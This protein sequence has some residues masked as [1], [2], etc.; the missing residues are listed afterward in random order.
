MGRKSR[1]KKERGPAAPPEAPAP[2]P[3]EP[4]S[5]D[6]PAWPDP[7]LLALVGAGLLVVVGVL[8]A[9]ELAR[10]PRAILV[11]QR[12]ALALAA[13]ALAAW[14]LR[15]RLSLDSEVGLWL[16]TAGL[17]ILALAA[18]IAPAWFDLPMAGIGERLGPIPIVVGA[19]LAGLGLLAGRGHPL[20]L[21]AGGAGCAVLLAGLLQPHAEVIDLRLA[22]LHHLAPFSGIRSAFV[23]VLLLAAAGG[24]G[25]IA[26]QARWGRP[27][28]VLLV[29][30]LPAWLLYRMTTGEL[31]G[32][33]TALLLTAGATCWMAAL[34][35]LRAAR[36]RAT[37]G[38]T[39]EAAG[40]VLAVG[41]W[42]LLKSYTW[43]W[44]TTDENI[45]FYD[46][47]LWAQGQLPYKDFFFAHPPMHIGV[48]ALAFKIFGFSLPLAKGIPVVA[49]L[50]TGL[51]LWMM[52]RRRVG[53]LPAGL[54][55]VAFLFAH[56][57]LQASTNL[58]GVNLTSFWLVLGLF[59]AT[60]GRSR[61]IA[62]GVALGL[63]V[64]TGFYAVAAA[65]AIVVMAL[66]ANDGRGWRMAAALV[67]V[68]G[69]INLACYFMAGPAFVEG[70]YEFHGLKAE[71]DLTI[72]FLK[73]LYHHTPLFMG[74]L[75]AP[76][77][78]AWVRFRGVVIPGQP[79]DPEDRTSFFS[80]WSLWSEPG[81]GAMKVSW[82]VGVAL[83]VEFTM[84][85]ELYGFYFTLIIPYAAIATGYTLAVLIA[86][87]LH[88]L[89]ELN[90]GRVSLLSW[91]APALVIAWSLWVP[92]AM[93][94]NW[95]FSNRGPP[96]E[97]A[98]AKGPNPEWLK[99]GEP[100]Y[101]RWIEP[102]AL[103]E[104]SGPIVRALFWRDHRLRGAMTPG[105]R[106][107]LWQK[108]LHLDVADELGTWVRENSAEDETVAGNSLVA[109]AVALLSGR[110]IAANFVDTNAKRFKTELTSLETFFTRIC[111]DNIRF[112]I[113]SPSGYFNDRMLSQLPTVRRWFR[114]LKRFESPLNKFKRPRPWAVTIWGLKDEPVPGQ[115][116]C[117]WIEPQARPQRAT[118]RQR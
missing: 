91:G 48:V 34:P 47:L 32:P 16:P 78:G 42:L 77:A 50:G 97:R 18:G 103:N 29:A 86:A 30:W 22:V 44:S 116:R 51:L 113:S 15:G 93:E 46:A 49:A 70:V 111:A 54:G 74:M 73:T 71:K 43:R 98:R 33:A 13:G 37:L 72:E 12:A 88:E 24:I 62:A 101:Y 4:E 115:P 10:S 68:A 1:K 102:A 6:P 67:S 38:L 99:A 90:L 3:E 83:L 79:Y 63:A 52:M 23:V 7:W 45:Y 60:E 9:P 55:L 21:V 104:L 26:T 61:A 96:P 112:L 89:R 94:T 114:P 31:S 117:E 59:W 56:E 81:L 65:L 17:G 2:P 8:S 110:R 36:S 64:T 87:V 35:H 76:V 107:F 92:L 95:V 82:L 105:Y 85:R 27:L 69:G 14:L 28:G 100:R 40:V 53:P 5:T 11:V 39:I 108:S 66:F 84:F 41:L 106:H 58:N 75:L 25:A 80:P 109:P 57:L 19:P 20:A 118:R